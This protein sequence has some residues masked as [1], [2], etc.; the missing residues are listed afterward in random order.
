ME[1]SKCP[2]CGEEPHFLEH[3]EK[4]Y[5]YGC[6]AYIE[7]GMEHVC[8]DEQKKEECAA[9]I[10]EEL[11]SLDEEPRIE[12]RNCG[13]ELEGLK[14]GMLYCY[15]CE[16]YQVEKAAEPEPSPK[17]ANDA[18]RILDAALT[19]PASNPP[20][21]APGPVEPEAEPASVSKDI[22]AEPVKASTEVPLG[23]GDVR[24]CSSC[25]QALKWIEKYQRHYCYGCKRYAPKDGGEKAAPQDPSIQP[26]KACPGCGSELKFIE[27][28]SEYYC[29]ACRKYP[30]RE[31]GKAEP[32][33]EAEPS[34]E[35]PKKSL[36]LLCPKCKRELKWIEKYSRHYCNECKEYAPKGFGEVEC[37]SGEKKQCPS[38]KE[39]MKFVA[40]Y[41]EWYC[42][43]CRKYSLRPSKPIL[44]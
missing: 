27:K 5:C 41:N 23:D 26:P 18:Q 7:D 19:E 31:A 38:C 20:E 24:L 33:K 4:W 15:V 29:F 43:K 13:A 3:M 2:K 40:E 39:T 16:T 30:L 9:A 44:L 10:K 34:A 28:Y 25:G 14:D 17:E 36:A 8:V 11:K 6:N 32:R 1:A 42:Y 37:G 35:A 21:T 12:C 22:P